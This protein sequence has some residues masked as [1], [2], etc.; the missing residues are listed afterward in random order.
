[1]GKTLA[2]NPMQRRTRI[3]DPLL[4]KLASSVWI[5]PPLDGAVF[6]GDDEGATLAKDFLTKHPTGF[7]R[8]DE[9][10]IGTPEGSSLY[11]QL[12][13]RGRPWSSKEDVWWE[14]SWRMARAAKGIGHVFASSRMTEQ[15]PLEEFRHKYTT[16]AFANTVL[17][18]VELPELEANPKVT[19]IYINGRLL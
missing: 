8:L 1:V 15:R 9:L 18:K 10:L 11:R 6:Y 13:D 7:A 3:S 14:L 17:E 4:M 12:M 2:A 16:G 5:K 19:A